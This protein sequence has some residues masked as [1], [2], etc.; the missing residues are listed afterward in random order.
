MDVAF[1]LL[2]GIFMAGARDTLRKYYGRAERLLS[3][4]RRGKRAD[5]GDGL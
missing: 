3:S 4:R 5:S 2:E 1:V